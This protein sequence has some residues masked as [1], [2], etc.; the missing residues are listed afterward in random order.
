MVV[1][2]DYAEARK[3]SDEQSKFYGL[4]VLVYAALPGEDVGEESKLPGYHL[5][6]DAYC[7]V[8]DWSLC[9]SPS[10]KKNDLGKLQRPHYDLT[11]DDG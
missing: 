7:L 9:S 1:I 6:T 11:I 3:F 4:Q 10:Q 2:S 8:D 5:M